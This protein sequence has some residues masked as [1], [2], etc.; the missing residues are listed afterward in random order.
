MTKLRLSDETQLIFPLATVPLNHT[1]WIAAA[2]VKFF[3]LPY[4]SLLTCIK[5]KH[6]HIIKTQQPKHNF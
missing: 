2:E 4:F 1:V 5:N 6:F 3:F